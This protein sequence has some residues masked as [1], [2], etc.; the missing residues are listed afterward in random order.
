[1]LATTRVRVGQAFEW[2]VAA[3]FLAATL[4][5]ALL[6]AGQLSALRVPTAPPPAGA[7]APDV[8]TAIPGPAISVPVLQFSDTIEVRVGDTLERVSSLLGPG[9]ETGIPAGASRLGPRAT[10]AY[11]YGSTRVLLVFEPFE[12]G[13]AVRV[14]GIYIQ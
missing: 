14:A 2:A 3:A 13:G 7:A 11:R 1:M 6:I 10:R 4:A 8:P 5:V 12:R 9:E